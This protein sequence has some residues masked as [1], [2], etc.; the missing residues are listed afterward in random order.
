MSQNL[1]VLEEPERLLLSEFRDPEKYAPIV[2]YIAGNMPE[3]T[4]AT[5]AFNKTD[6]QFT[7][8]FLTI[9]GLTPLRNLRQILAEIKKSRN[10]LGE[11]HF[12][13]RKK[14]IEIRQLERRRKERDARDLDR[15]MIDTEIGE[16]EFQIA[17]IMENVEGALRKIANFQ[18]QYQDIQAAAKLGE[19]TE[20]DFEREEERYHIT[21]AFAQALNAARAHGGYIDEGNQIYMQQIGINGTQA[22]IEVR[23]YMQAELDAIRRGETLDYDREFQW[24]NAMAEKF[25]GCSARLAKLRGQTGEISDVALTI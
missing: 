12:A 6:S 16:R 22:Q 18:K 21:R 15:E 17:M 9:T 5:K 4:R 24:L 11:A 14:R 13:I 2:E 1:A 20:A 8:N 7:N 10:A 25:R 3:I 19:W 23:D